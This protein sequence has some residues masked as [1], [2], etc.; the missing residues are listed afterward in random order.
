MSVGSAVAAGGL[1]LETI[2]D[3]AAFARVAGEW[4][5]LVRAMPRPSPMLLHGWLRTWWRHFGNDGKLA[6]HV[7]YRDGKLVGA[8]PLCV[9]SGRGLDVLTFVGAGQ[10]A[11]ADLLVDPRDGVDAARALVDRAAETSHDYADLF[12]LPVGSRLAAELGEDRLRLLERIEAPVLDVEGS[13]DDVYRARMSSKKRSQH[14]RR[15]RHLAELGRVDI[16]V[17]RTSDELAEALEDTFRIHELR[18]AGRPDG[19]RF[20]TPEGRPFHRDAIRALAEVDAARIATM[21]LDGRLIAFHY[22]FL[23]ERC[24]YVHRIAF[25]PSFGRYSPGFLNT[26]DAMEAA[27]DEG[28]TRIEFLGGADRYKL[29]FTDRFE[30]LC[31]GFG[32]VGTVRGSAA[33]AAKLGAIRLRKQLKR[34]QT[35]RRFYINGLAP[36]RRLMARLS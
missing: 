4:D 20:A 13:W 36:A 33:V 14:R 3:D 7:A 2:S 25:D 10:S 26:L 30:P 8:L 35:L 17:A 29:E 16:E 9:Q 21:R 19:S 34:S 22:Y 15:R 6:V 5:E 31:Q 27:V 12:G 24:M 11:L 23:F 18:W 1:T 28:A 32:L